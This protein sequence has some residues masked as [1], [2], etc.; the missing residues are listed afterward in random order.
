[1]GGT[2]G[3]NADFDYDMASAIWTIPTGQDVLVCKKPYGRGFLLYRK[4]EWNDKTGPAL[5]ADQ[6]GCV[7][8]AN[9]YVGYHDPAWIVPL[10]VRDHAISQ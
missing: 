1:M 5:E 10:T 9:Q 4:D 8:Q 3:F 7:L 6:D 2:R